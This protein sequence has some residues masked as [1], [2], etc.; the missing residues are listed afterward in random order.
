MLLGLKTLGTVLTV[1]STAQFGKEMYDKYKDKRKSRQVDE[2]HEFIGSLDIQALNDAIE[3]EDTDALIDAVEAILD[4]ANAVRVKSDL[5]ELQDDVTDVAKNIFSTVSKVATKVAG[6]VGEK[7]DEVKEAVDD[8]EDDDL[9]TPTIPS[10]KE[11][12]KSSAVLQI[13]DKNGIY[14]ITVNDDNVS[15]NNKKKT[16]TFITPANAVIVTQLV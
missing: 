1:A 8:L 3:T 5:E 4:A 9:E 14:R 11:F 7:L 15:T 13:E 6:K 12:K 16:V 2:V 10:F